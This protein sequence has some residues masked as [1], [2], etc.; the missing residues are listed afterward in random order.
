[1]NIFNKLGFV[2]VVLLATSVAN[3][4]Q[5]IDPNAGVAAGVTQQVTPAVAPGGPVAKATVIQNSYYHPIRVVYRGSGRRGARGP[6][7]LMGPQ[8]PSGPAGAPGSVVVFSGASLAGTPALPV[9]NPGGSPVIHA[10]YDPNWV[11]ILAALAVFV[12]LTFWFGIH[13]FIFFRPSVNP[14]VVAA[15]E[16]IQY[17][18][19]HEW[20]QRRVQAQCQRYNYNSVAG[21][22]VIP[23]PVTETTTTHNPVKGTTTTKTKSSKPAIFV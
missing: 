12:T 15:L 18:A 23:N 21:E 14:S 9:S 5:I 20:R 8:G 13:G 22:G 1:M 17:G 6:Q 2:F 4:Q 11:W 19:G 10:G 3:G 16:R 7:G